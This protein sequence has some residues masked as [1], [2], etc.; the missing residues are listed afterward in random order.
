LR[1]TILPGSS[2]MTVGGV[3]QFSGLY[4]PASA[5]TSTDPSAL[6]TINRSASGRC[7]VSRPVY[8]TAQR[9]TINR[10]AGT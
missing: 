9:A 8:S 6:T 3:I 1:T 2:S 7:A 4:P 10:I 5:C